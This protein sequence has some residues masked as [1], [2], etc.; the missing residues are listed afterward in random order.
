VQAAWTGVWGQSGQSVWMQNWLQQTATGSSKEFCKAKGSQQ[1]RCPACRDGSWECGRCT[2]GKQ[3]HRMDL[4]E[5][6]TNRCV[7][8]MNHRP[9]AAPLLQASVQ[10]RALQRAACHPPGLSCQQDLRV[11][12]RSFSILHAGRL[13]L[14]LPSRAHTTAGQHMMQS[15]CSHEQGVGRVD[16]V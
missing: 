3:H 14:S 15:A 6:N 10:D 4:D 11:L 8:P 13:D 1:L 16:M 2:A 12:L 9:S 7:I 5:T